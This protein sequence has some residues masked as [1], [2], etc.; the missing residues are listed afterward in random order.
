MQKYTLFLNNLSLT[1]LTFLGW[2]QVPLPILAT[3]SRLPGA[4]RSLPHIRHGLRFLNNIEYDYLGKGGDG[5]TLVSDG[6]LPGVE[7][8]LTGEGL[9]LPGRPSPLILPLTA[10]C[11]TSRGEGVDP[12]SRPS[13]DRQGGSKKGRPG[14]RP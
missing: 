2:H 9:L 8:N 7:R 14:G 5:T 10:L 11:G 6:E 13:P 1:L 4:E 3:I 12:K